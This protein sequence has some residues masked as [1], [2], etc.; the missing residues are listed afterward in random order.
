M[1]D[2]SLR[3]YLI[4][5]KIAVDR[6]GSPLRDADGQKLVDYSCEGGG[7]SA[8]RGKSGHRRKDIH[9]ALGIALRVSV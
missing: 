1:N 4:E 8:N 5:D 9:P 6:C 2:Y 7:Y 3:D